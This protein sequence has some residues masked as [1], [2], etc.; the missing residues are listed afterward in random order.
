M[1]VTTLWFSCL[2]CQRGYKTRKQNHK[3]TSGRDASCDQQKGIHFDFCEACKWD[4]SL[5][6]GRQI[7]KTFPK[8]TR[9]RIE[10]VE[11][12]S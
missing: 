5:E 11:G 6:F 12:D 10:G 9:L 4:L 8:R 3:C 1:G 7:N 2:N